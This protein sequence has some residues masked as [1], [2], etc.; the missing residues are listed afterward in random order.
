M[1]GNVRKPSEK[2][3]DLLTGR[4]IPQ[5]AD[6][7]ILSWAEFHI[8]QAAC[9]ICAMGD[10]KQRRDAMDKAPDTLRPFLEREVKRLWPL[11]RDKR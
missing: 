6:P 3:N 11:T 1:T 4:V 7:A 2:L 5:N 10:I 9:E 8:W